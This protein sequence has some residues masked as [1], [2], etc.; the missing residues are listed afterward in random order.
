MKDNNKKYVHSE[1]TIKKTDKNLNYNIYRE[2]NYFIQ[3]NFYLQYNYKQNPILT[4][5]ASSENE[6]KQTKNR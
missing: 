5:D 2:Y 4:Y 6:R 1:S 3:H